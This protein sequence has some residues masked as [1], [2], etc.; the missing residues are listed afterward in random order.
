MAIPYLNHCHRT[1][2][3]VYRI[4]YPQKP[5]I[6]TSKF[7]EGN[8]DLKPNGTNAIVAASTNTF[9]G[10]L[11]DCRSQANVGISM[12][13]NSDATNVFTNTITLFKSLDA[14]N[15]ETVAGVTISPTNNGTNVTT[16][17]TNIPTQGAGYMKMTWVNPNT[18]ANETNLTIQYGLKIQAP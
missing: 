5:I 11:I 17:I 9:G 18:T 15:F 4:T 10:A 16:I 13:W 14:I 1:D 8:F 2:N 3:K 6:R 12:T 7:S